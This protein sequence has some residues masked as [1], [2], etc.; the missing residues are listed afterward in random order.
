[1]ILPVPRVIAIDDEPGLNGPHFRIWF[2]I[3]ISERQVCAKWGAGT[4]RGPYGCGNEAVREAQ[5][6]DR[7]YR[8]YLF[9]Q[10]ADS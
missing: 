9:H 2:L 5:N 6:R 1:M 7:G 4:D 10:A 3:S 8:G